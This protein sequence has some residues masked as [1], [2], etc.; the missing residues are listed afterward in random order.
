MDSPGGL[1]LC[2]RHTPFPIGNT[3]V[4]HG[5]LPLDK[6]DWLRFAGVGVRAFLHECLG[7]ISAYCSIFLSRMSYLAVALERYGG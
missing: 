3:P 2:I 4:S 6:Q 7:R 1:G 5:H